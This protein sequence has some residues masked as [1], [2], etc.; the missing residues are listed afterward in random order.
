MPLVVILPTMVSSSSSHF[1][2]AQGWNRRRHGSWPFDAWGS[3]QGGKEYR[4]TSAQRRCKWHVCMEERTGSD[5]PEVSFL[6]FF[7]GVFMGVWYSVLF[8]YLTYV[9]ACRLLLPSCFLRRKT[10]FD[11]SQ[12]RKDAI[13]NADV[14]SWDWSKYWQQKGVCQ[15][16]LFPWPSQAFKIPVWTIKESPLNGTMSS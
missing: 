12:P 15:A 3:W 10:R 6:F 2:H 9:W 1:L 5:Q 11:K 13:L 8:L 4:K 7:F 16:M 14:E